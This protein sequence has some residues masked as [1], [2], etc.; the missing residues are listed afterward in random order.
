MVVLIWSA[1]FNRE[2]MCRWSILEK[3]NLKTHLC[4]GKHL[5]NTYCMRES[6]PGE[7]CIQM[8]S[9]GNCDVFKGQ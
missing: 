4:T 9:C 1:L 2:Y 5:V 8:T 7:G 6:G 3:V